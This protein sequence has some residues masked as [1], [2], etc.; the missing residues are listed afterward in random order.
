MTE[1]IVDFLSK[2]YPAYMIGHAGFLMF[3]I[4]NSAYLL[5]FEF[6]AF[7]RINRV[8]GVCLSS[9]LLQCGSCITSVIR[10]NIGEPH[11]YWGLAGATFGI[12]ATMGYYTNYS[13]LAFHGGDAQ[14]ASNIG[15][16]FSI[17]A[18][19]V[20][21]YTTVQIW[22]FTA[23]GFSA[24]VPYAGISNLYALIS[25][26]IGSRAHKAGKLQ[27]DPS[28]VSPDT[29]ANVFTALIFLQITALAGGATGLPIFS[30]PGTGLTFTVMTITSI[31]IPK[32]ESVKSGELSSLLDKST[33]GP[34]TSTHSHNS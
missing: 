17:V 24:F 1:L 9:T 6:F 15:L 28:F 23:K 2:S 30:F 32:L 34:A 18:G 4:L 3:N 27:C 20:I 13:Y 14:K 11:S 5:I 25:L 33:Q 26:I 7:G 29:M 22:D 21:T 16:G 31:F 12:W 19:A 10:Y 8:S